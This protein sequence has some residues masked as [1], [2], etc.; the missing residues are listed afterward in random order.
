[1]KK[2]LTI[3]FTF[4]AI[5]IFA[6]K[7]YLIGSSN[8][9]LGKHLLYHLT[10]EN[11]PV[12]NTYLKTN[13]FK[14]KSYHY[15]S[16]ITP[17]YSDRNLLSTDLILEELNG[18]IKNETAN[19]EEVV[20]YTIL[21]Q[22][23]ESYT[24]FINSSNETVHHIYHNTSL[25]DT[26]ISGNV[27]MPD[28]ITTSGESYGGNYADNNDQTNSDLD[29]ELTQITFIGSYE[30]GE[31]LLENEHL[32]I[33]NQSS[34][35]IQPTKRTDSIFQFNRS[36]QGFEE[37]HAMYHIS[38][39]ANYLKD[40]LGFD[41]MDYQIAVDVYALNGSDQSEF[42]GSTTPPRLN[43]GEGCV[44]DAEDPDIL[45][46]EYAHGV[47]NSAAPGTL[48]GGERV[49]MDEGY[50]DYWAAAYSKKLNSNNYKTIFNWDG[51]NDCWN[52]RTIDHNRK[53]PDDLS[54]NKYTSGELFGA[55]L[56]DIRNNLDDEVADKLILQ[57]NYSWFPNMTFTNA[58]ELIL[59]ADTLLYN[60]Q[61]AGML[62]YLAC[63]R[64]FISSNCEN[65]I[66]ELGLEAEIDYALLNQGIL[67]IR[68]LTSSQLAK[69]YDSQ[70]KLVLNKTITSEGTILPNMSEGVYILEVDGKTLKF[71]K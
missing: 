36:Q 20:K 64:G 68:N 2:L 10:F 17:A 13:I 31:Y 42:I 26:T 1:M 8:S 47:S 55:M 38:R 54:G 18:F 52:G 25:K 30:N 24:L 22:K 29:N 51:H 6:Q 19:Y 9:L 33:V 40:T 41:I 60:N 23:G 27:F 50:G 14:D 62:L 11:Q 35:D 71:I 63:E 7:N 4:F 65:S 53:Y 12:F 61:H 28:P 5:T 58:L 32:K 15:S 66:D 43:F 44:D 37:V 57:S 49:A 69:I 70:G 34:P 59:Q 39:F 48:I 21:S 46:H 56:M 16:E 3:L 45:I 67:R